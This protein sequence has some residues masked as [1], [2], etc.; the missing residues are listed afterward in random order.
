GLSLPVTLV[1]DYPSPAAL[2]DHLYQQLIP[3]VEGRN[4]I[5]HLDALEAAVAATRPDGAEQTELVTRL[6]G[7]LV[8]LSS[9]DLSPDDTARDED[10]ASADVSE[11]MN[12]IDREFGSGHS[13]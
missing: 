11:L 3:E 7:L 1:F 12:L 5:G 9:A 8:S 13:S 10:L 6:R 2:T 4:L